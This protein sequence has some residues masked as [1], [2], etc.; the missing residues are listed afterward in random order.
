MPEFRFTCLACGVADPDLPP[1][2]E[3]IL[4]EDAHGWPV[5]V[6]TTAVQRNEYV[7]TTFSWPR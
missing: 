2:H 1:G 4:T 3:V 5:M 6:C 7:T